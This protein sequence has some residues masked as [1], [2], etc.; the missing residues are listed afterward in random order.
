MLIIS[1]IYQEVHCKEQGRCPH[2][3]DNR[4]IH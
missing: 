2:S 3:H 1:R 4:S